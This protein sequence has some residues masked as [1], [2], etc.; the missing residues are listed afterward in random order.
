MDNNKNEKLNIVKESPALKMDKL[1]VRIKDIN[2]QLLTNKKLTDSQRKALEQE[3]TVLKKNMAVIERSTSLTASENAKKR[4][5]KSIIW[6]VIIV[7]T[8][9]LAFAGGI[10]YYVLALNDYDDNY[11]R[12]SVDMSNMN[13]TFTSTSVSGEQIPLT[14]NPG[15]EFEVVIITKNSEKILGDDQTF[16]W[17][18]LYVRFKIELVIDDVVYSD[19][20][21][22]A[23]DSN[24]WI[25]ASDDDDNIYDSFDGYYYLAYALEPNQE[26]QL[27]DSL[28]FS[29]EITREIGGSNAE[30]LVTIDV[31]EA[32]VSGVL[33]RDIWP[34][35]P[36]EWV[37]IIV[38]PDN[39]PSYTAD[40]NSEVKY[41]GQIVIICSL[42]VM[43]LVVVFLIRKNRPTNKNK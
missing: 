37:S 25:C 30:I 23:P 41:I 20:I 43:Y 11:V 6:A 42:A 16:D 27:I 17:A 12:I 32:S 40:P 24:F 5:K 4:K 39:Q 35:S 13:E 9:F 28:K 26:V 19:L 3:K 33:N 22:Y 10:V 36:V 31:V 21:E 18:N 38:D 29:E 8:M 7:V 15:D 2:I 34:T 14:V 1:K